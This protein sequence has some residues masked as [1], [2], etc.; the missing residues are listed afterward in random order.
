M[1]VSVQSMG[2]WGK[3]SVRTL[4]NLFLKT[5]T[6]GAVTTEAGSLFRYFTTL[7]FGGGSHLGVPYSGALIGRVERE[8]EK[9]S[10]DQYPKDP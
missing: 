8:G 3:T 9:T 4:P 5:L 10:S 6:Q 1:Y 2:G 7:S